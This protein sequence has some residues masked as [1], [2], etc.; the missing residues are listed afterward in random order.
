M[1]Y[2]DK[3]GSWHGEKGIGSVFRVSADLDMFREFR[4]KDDTYAKR[5]RK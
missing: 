5:W 2:R 1:L 4:E 3:D